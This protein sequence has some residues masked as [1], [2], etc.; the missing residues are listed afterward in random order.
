MGRAVIEF[1]SCIVCQQNLTNLLTELNMNRY[2]IHNSEY[3]LSLDITCARSK[4]R[5][6]PVAIPPFVV[7]RRRRQGLHHH[8]H[9]HPSV[10]FLICILFKQPFVLLR[11]LHF[12]HLCHS[13]Q[14][15]YFTSDVWTTGKSHRVASSVMIN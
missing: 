12:H 11:L 8:H 6:L 14:H 15:V 10:S 7:N 13:C 1:F 5:Q 3:A 2:I 9:H 4:V